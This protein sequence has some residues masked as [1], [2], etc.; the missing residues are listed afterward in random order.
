[1]TPLIIADDFS[2]ACDAAARAALHGWSAAA[3]LASP[4]EGVHADLLAISTESRHALP[5]AARA[6]MRSLAP[7]LRGRPLYKKIDSTLRGPWIDEVDELL[8]LTDYSQAVVCPAFPA[9][10]RT[11]RNGWL[12]VDDQP[13]QQ[14]RC[15]FT[16]RDASTED[17]L[18]RIASEV[19]SSIL[20]VGS[21]GLA[22]HVFQRDAR[23]PAS[24]PAPLPATAGPWIVLIGSDQ[25]ASQIQLQYVAAFA[26]QDML[27]NPASYPDS[28]AGVFA[29]GGET[30]SC[31][32]RDSGAHGVTALRE[33]LPG[34]PA[35]LILGGRYNGTVMITKAGG[36][37]APDAILQAIQSL[38]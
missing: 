3:L 6:C 34:I 18:A 29:S 12:C 30:A 10:G 20:P 4:V 22:L 37:G 11:V 7:F 35:G 14:I 9:Q 2:G 24:S 16:V 28:P 21:A 8:S 25:P 26:P 38:Q 36:F 15:P 17:D 5:R 31:F 19:C 13:V 27:L 1:M 32:L 33:L 23:P